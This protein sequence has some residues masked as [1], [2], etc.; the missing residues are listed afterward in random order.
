MKKSVVRTILLLFVAITYVNVFASGN[1]QQ[2]MKVNIEKMYQAKTVE[3]LTAVSGVFYRIA[4]T[5]KGEWLPWYY[6]CYSRV[7]IT[8]FVKDGDEVDKQLDVAQQYMDWLIKSAPDNSEVHV[9]QALIYAMRITNSSRG[10]KYIAL[11]NAALD[12]A[13]ALDKS[14]PRVYYCKGNNIYHTPAFVGGGKEKATPLFEKAKQL[15]EQ[16]EAPQELWPQWGAYY[17]QI[18]LDT[19]NK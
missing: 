19:C 18:M 11:S 13:E 10:M 15:Y 2:V 12:R 17:N 4:E 7:R 3:E 1:Y 9:L 5:E 16:W 8:F 14:N 6:A